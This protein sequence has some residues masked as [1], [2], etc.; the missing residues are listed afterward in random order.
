[1]A[2]TRAARS[3]L[4]A[5]LVCCTLSGAADAASLAD[6]ALQ[7]AAR[8]YGNWDFETEYFEVEDR[9]DGWTEQAGAFVAVALRDGASEETADAYIERHRGPMKKLAE[10]FVFNPTQ[11]TKRIFRVLRRQCDKIIRTEPEMKAF[12]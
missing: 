5:S 9:S 8:D 4:S 6:Q 2:K 1:M 7:C 3:L 10:D 12:R 11:E